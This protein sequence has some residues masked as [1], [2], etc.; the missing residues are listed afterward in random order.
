[1][2]EFD[3]I[4]YTA[5]R[6]E[7]WNAFVARS[8]Q[9]TFLFDRGYMDY[10]ADRFEDCSLM[11]YRK[12]K[13]YALLP[14]NRKG[15]TLHSHQGLTYGGLLTDERATAANVV[16]LFAEM[17]EYLKTSGIKKVVYKAIPYIYHRLPAEE[18][19]YAIYR[20]SHARLTAREIST[21]IL[22]RLG[23]KWSY[24]RKYGA[25]HARKLGV[26]VERCDDLSAFWPI[27]EGNLMATH[28]VKPVHTLAEMQL[29]QSRFPERILLYVARNAESEAVAGTLL[30]LTPQVV[31]TQYISAN[32]EGKRLCA[33]D[34]IFQRLLKDDF[35]DAHYFD[36]GKSTE[37]HGHTLNEHLIFQKEGFG[38]R[39]VCYDSYEWEL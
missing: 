23:T 37:D 33:I 31:H 32:A 13:L 24:N 29:L 8:K 26:T 25:N 20:T 4:P 22:P 19:L 3:I 27:L 11:F 35:S 16:T 21:T 34:A 9:G 38:G 12:G 28:G 2:N 6:C 18:D 1:M 36:F 5:E 17:N 14:A 7:E 15:D 30:Y 10:H 39:G